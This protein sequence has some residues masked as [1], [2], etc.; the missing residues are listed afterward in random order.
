MT[1]V[2]RRGSC[3]AG[4]RRPAGRG[5]AQRR[6]WRSSTG[7]PR[8]CSAPTVALVDRR[9]AAVL[10]ADGGARRPAAR[11]GAQRRRWRSSTGGPPRCSAPTVALVDRRAAAVLGAGLVLVDRIDSE[12]ARHGPTGCERRRGGRAARSPTR[13]GGKLSAPP[14]GKDHPRA[15]RPQA[16]HEPRANEAPGELGPVG[17][18][19]ART[20]AGSLT[21]ATTPVPRPC[22]R[23][24]R[25]RGRRR[26]GWPG[27]R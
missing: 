21:I 22:P 13:L 26:S 14:R 27:R 16:G 23:L 11:R 24:C 19:G 18:R 5:G 2:P 17:H 6:R 8:R 7:G 10:S 20:G 15:Y 4:A 12:S 25:P 1:T 3:T 9:A